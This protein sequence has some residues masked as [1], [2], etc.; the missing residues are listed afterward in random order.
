MTFAEA[1]ARFATRDKAGEKASV[2]ETP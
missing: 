2:L 1:E